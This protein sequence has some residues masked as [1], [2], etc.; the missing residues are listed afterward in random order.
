MP[1]QLTVP[2]TTT[3]PTPPGRRPLLPVVRQV[4]VILLV[5]VAVGALAGVVWEWIWTPPSGVVLNHQWLQDESGLR[6]DFSGTGTYVVVAAIAGLLGGAVLGAVFDRRE[7]LT[8]VTVL[9]G[10]ALA[11]WVMY[12]VG[13]ALAPTDPRDL[14]GSVK[15][16]THLPG[17]LIVS[18]DSPFRALPGG[19]MVGLVIVFLGLSR[20]HRLPD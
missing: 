10:S 13:L 4:V 15:D 19:A 16:G 5:L 18:G 9:L 3:T 20:R 6:N 7:L 2:A 17:R 11:A 1:D 14:A 8:L 12:R